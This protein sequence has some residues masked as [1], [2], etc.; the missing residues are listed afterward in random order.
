MFD[1]TVNEL[2]KYTHHEEATLAPLKAEDIMET[3]FNTFHIDQPILEAA[4]SLI[5]SNSTGDPVVNS[6]GELVGFLST[7]DCLKQLYDQ[8]VNKVPYFGTVNDY[9]STTVECFGKQTL[10]FPILESFIEKPFQAYPIVENN[11]L[12]GVVRRQTVLQELLTKGVSL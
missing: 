4:K 7:K 11:K 9:M 2:S 8:A 5:R 12:V 6:R 10:I 3:K 1:S